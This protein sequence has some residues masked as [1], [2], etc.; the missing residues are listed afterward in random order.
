MLA[1]EI[2]GPMGKPFQALTAK[3]DSRKKP[4]HS[5]LERDIVVVIFG[6]AILERMRSRN[7]LHLLPFTTL[8]VLA[9][10]LAAVIGRASGRACRRGAMVTRA[11]HLHLIRA[12]LGAVPVHAVLV[13]PLAGTQTAFHVHLRALAQVLAGDLGQAAIEDRA[14][15][16]GGLL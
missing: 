2:K 12:D 11:E 4:G 8:A 16:L 5:N 13:G 15:P 6:I 3:S 9:R 1:H 10:I 7:G 14:V